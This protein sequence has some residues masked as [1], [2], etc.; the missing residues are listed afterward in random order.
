MSGVL[1]S[2]GR[3]KLSEQWTITPVGGS[4]K[5]P[6]F[7]AL[8]GAKNGLKIAT[9][10]DIQKKDHQTVENLYKKKLLKKQN[11]LTFA[12]F[13]GF[14]EADIEDMF[15][16][17]FYLELVNQEYSAD[18]KSPVT[19][20]ML[21]SKSPR[22]I[23]RLEECFRKNP[24]ISGNAFSHFRPARYFA[25]NITKL[26]KDIPSEAIDRFESAF[27]MLNNLL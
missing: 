1:E 14:S 8:I 5:V 15:G 17:D 6:T 18:L 13:T 24:L 12:D 16:V 22:I 21:T 10:N 3:E 2:L 19:L 23:Q 27:K 26:T 11:V 25:E 9:L 20:K 4:D 7:V